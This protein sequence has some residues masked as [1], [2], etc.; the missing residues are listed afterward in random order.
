MNPNDYASMKLGVLSI[1]HYTLDGV[2]VEDLSPAQ[3]FALRNFADSLAFHMKC[4]LNRH[5][6]EALK[7]AGIPQ[8]ALDLFAKK[9]AP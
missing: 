9:E 2:P 3:K 8:D 6:D 7:D 5:I 1:P 4:S